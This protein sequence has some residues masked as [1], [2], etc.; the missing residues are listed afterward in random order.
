MKT[1]E[2]ILSSKLQNHIYLSYLVDVYVVE[3]NLTN[4]GLEEWNHKLYQMIHKEEKN[5]KRIDH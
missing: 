3:A 2:N 4:N 1:L 5:R